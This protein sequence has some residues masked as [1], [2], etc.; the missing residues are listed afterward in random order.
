[1]TST[2]RHLMML[3]MVIL[4]GSWLLPGAGPQGRCHRLHSCPSDHGSYTCGDLWRCDQCPDNQY[5][6]ADKPRLGPS[7]TRTP[8]QPAPVPSVP[9]TPSAVTVCFTPGGN[10]TDTIVNA[11]GNAKRM[12]LGQGYSF[13]S[14][15]IAKAPLDAHLHG[16]QAQYTKNWEAH[17]Q[18]SQLYVD[19]GVCQ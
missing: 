1:M 10:C 12:I 8:A 15:P 13:I 4:V 18:H 7:P 17:R 6:L 16:I 5:C 2:R 3:Q 14:A 19:R 9:T 11:L